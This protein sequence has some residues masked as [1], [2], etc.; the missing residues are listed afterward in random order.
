[1]FFKMLDYI[2]IMVKFIQ[3]D[4]PEEVSNDLENDLRIIN[5]DL[6]PPAE[7]LKESPF[8]NKPA[9]VLKKTFKPPPLEEV[10]EE[11]TADIGEPPALSV[12]TIKPKKPLS[13]KQLANLERMRLK[14]VKK[15]QEQLEK[16]ISKNDITKSIEQP[17][18]YTEAE[19]LDMEQSE[20]DDWLKYMSRFDKMIKA[21]QQEEQRV[22]D[23]VYKKEKEIEDRIRKKIELENNQRNNISNK[24][25]E[26]VVPILQQQA[27]PDYGQYANMFGY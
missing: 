25:T 15:A 3:F 17:K 2:Y 21:K 6:P 27:Q 18:E 14:K 10:Q 26:S 7:D 9:R 5:E 22:A 11:D 24:I 19:M 8:I 1:M 23:E 4:E 13:K 20:F 16:T 12:K